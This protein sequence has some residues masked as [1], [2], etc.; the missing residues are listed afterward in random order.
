[1]G[2]P[3]VL[4]FRKTSVEQEDFKGEGAG[5]GAPLEDKVKWKEAGKGISG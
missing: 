1:M 5:F 4:R 2:Y 3:A